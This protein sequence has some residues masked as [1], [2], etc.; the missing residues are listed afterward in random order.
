VKSLV[1]SCDVCQRGGRKITT[2]TP[3]LHPIPVVST[4]HHI[5][6][7]FV[8]PVNPTSR[9]GSRYILTVS[10]YFSKFVFAVGMIT[11][12]SSHVA[13]ELFKMFMMFGLPRVIT[14]DQGSEFNNTLDKSIMDKLA[15][16]HRLT[17]PYHPQVCNTLN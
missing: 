10:D 9:H 17:T 13:N 11:K 16:D 2:D 1:A 14:S 12:E 8:G 3:E 4:W 15:V 5:G 6:I 7:D